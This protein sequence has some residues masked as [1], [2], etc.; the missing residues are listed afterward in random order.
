MAEYN[1]WRNYETWRV[2]TDW[3]IDYLDSLAKDGEKFD[4]I[5]SLADHLSEYGQTLIDDSAEI[6]GYAWN[7]A[8]SMHSDVNWE[9]LAESA[10]LELSTLTCSDCGE[11][12]NHLTEKQWS[13]FPAHALNGCGWET[14]GEYCDGCSIDYVGYCRTCAARND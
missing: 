3:G 12:F 13:K 11:E 14:S 4:S 8:N 7:L 1:G 2:A 9:E 5:G 6:S 10:I